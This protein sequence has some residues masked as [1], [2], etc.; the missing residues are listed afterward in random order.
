MGF[1]CTFAKEW[2]RERAVTLEIVQYHIHIAL[3]QKQNKIT[4]AYWED[5]IWALKWIVPGDSQWVEPQC[6]LNDSAI[7]PC[8][9]S[10]DFKKT[11]G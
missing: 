7:T 10:L 6:M 9:R 2:N 4:N 3:L 1:L 5:E 11:F 8:H